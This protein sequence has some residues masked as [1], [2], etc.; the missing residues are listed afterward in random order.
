MSNKS[1]ITKKELGRSLRLPVIIFM[2]Y[3][4]RVKIIKTMANCFILVV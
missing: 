1:L 2:L 4:H 3:L